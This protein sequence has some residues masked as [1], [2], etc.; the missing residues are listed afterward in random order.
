MRGDRQVLLLC[1]LTATFTLATGPR[2]HAHASPTRAYARSKAG[3]VL[4]LNVLVGKAKNGCQNEKG[5]FF[6]SIC[7]KV[8]S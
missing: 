5:L 2:P 6:C 3:F 8:D 1:M 7:V 4:V